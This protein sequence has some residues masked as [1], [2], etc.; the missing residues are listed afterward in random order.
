MKNGTSRYAN[1]HW[2]VEKNSKWGRLRFL[3]W[4]TGQYVHLLGAQQVTNVWFRAH[5]SQVDNIPSYQEG[6][7]FFFNLPSVEDSDM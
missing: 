2:V 3:S 7:L 5:R 1:S 6:Q 4:T